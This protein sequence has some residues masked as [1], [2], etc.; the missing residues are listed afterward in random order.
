[1]QLDSL[2]SFGSAGIFGWTEE[3]I[4]GLSTTYATISNI[5]L[6]SHGTA[7]HLVDVGL[8]VFQSDAM[9][10]AQNNLIEKFLLI[11]TVQIPILLELLLNGQ[12]VQWSYWS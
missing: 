10:G 3:P 11:S 9:L 6:F 1:M 4:L 2:G 7:P 5:N 12:Q 8:L